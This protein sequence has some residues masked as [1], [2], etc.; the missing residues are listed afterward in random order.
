MGRGTKKRLKTT[1][2]KVQLVKRTQ[3]QHTRR[4]PVKNL[5]V[6]HRLRNPALYKPFLAQG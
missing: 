2:L 5:S 1:D 3:F 4:W 6:A